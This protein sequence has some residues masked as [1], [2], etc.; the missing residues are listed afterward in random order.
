MDATMSFYFSIFIFALTY[1][2]I[3][4]E[5]NSPVDLCFTRS[6]ACHIQRASHPGNGAS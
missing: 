1:L 3:M 2:G 4:S 5:K 6:G